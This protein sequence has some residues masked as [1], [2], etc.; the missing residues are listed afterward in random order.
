MIQLYLLKENQLSHNNHR[1]DLQQ[2]PN[3]WCNLWS[4]LQMEK[5]LPILS[6][7]QIRENLI[8]SLKRSHHKRPSSKE[9]WKVIL[10]QDLVDLQ[11]HSWL[12]VQW[13]EQC[14]EREVYLESLVML[15]LLSIKTLL[16][17][18]SSRLLYLRSPNWLAHSKMGCKMIIWS[19]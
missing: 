8:L 2:P 18:K 17:S 16:T 5:E 10:H 11:S 3:H 4:T 9:T 13:A 12:L 1:E 6:G 7:K 15:R 19:A 14:W